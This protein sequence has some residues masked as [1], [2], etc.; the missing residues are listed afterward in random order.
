MSN[1][2]PYF[3]YLKDMNMKMV[4]IFVTILFINTAL[5]IFGTVQS[6]H[7]QDGAINFASQCSV[8]GGMVCIG[9]GFFY[10]FSL[11][12][13]TMSIKADRVGYL[14]ASLLWGLALAVGLALFSSVFDV[15]CKVILEGWTGMSV[16]VYSEMRWIQMGRLQAAT[17]IISR[18]TSNMALFSLA[19]S[20]G[21]IWYRLKIK[22]SVIL[23][24]IIPVAFTTYGVNFGMRNP[25]R[26]E[27][28]LDAITGPILFVITNPGI[29]TGVKIVAIIAFTLIGVRLLIKAPIKDYANDLI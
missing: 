4:A 8:V 5:S 27:Q 24:L 7:I 25:E 28:I 19:F 2:K 26:I 10:S 14:K 1:Y 29:F 22:T 17:D 21:A 20:V 12:T 11:F 18:I 3:R 23:F 9:V 6:A 13:S 16:K 15:L